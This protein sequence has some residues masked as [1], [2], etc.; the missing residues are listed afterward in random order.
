MSFNSTLIANLFDS[1]DESYGT[2]LA[3]RCA[4]A[5]TLLRQQKEKE[6]LECQAC[7]KAKMAEQKKTGGRGVKKTGRGG[8]KTER[9]RSPEKFGQTFRGGPHRCRRTTMAQ[10]LDED[11]SATLISSFQQGDEP[12]WPSAS[13]QEATCSIPAIKNSGGSPMTR[14]VDKRNGDVSRWWGK[15]VWEVH[16]LRNLVYSLNL[17]ISIVRIVSFSANFFL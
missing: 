1:D 10:E 8:D 2:E 12:H 17:A 7:K 15:F 9:R 13:D 6:C 11:L 4:E 14:R 16:E 5:K 3:R